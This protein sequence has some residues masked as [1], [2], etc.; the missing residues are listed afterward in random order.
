[1]D[2]YEYQTMTMQDA[3]RFLHISQKTL[4]RRIAKKIV[5]APIEVGADKLFDRQEWMSWW[6]DRV[7]EG[8]TK[9]QPEV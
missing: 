7:E 5:P 2:K 8:K 6:E 3:A 9:F 4:K 1:M